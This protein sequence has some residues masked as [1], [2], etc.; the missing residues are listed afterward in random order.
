MDLAGDW[1]LNQCA[2]IMMTLFALCCLSTVQVSVDL[3][4]NGPDLSSK[5]LLYS[6]QIVP[7]FVSDEVDRETKMAITARPTNA[8]QVSFGVFREIKVDN[9]IH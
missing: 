5:L 4:R 6:V 1:M 2:S 8:M 7:V 3:C 9:H